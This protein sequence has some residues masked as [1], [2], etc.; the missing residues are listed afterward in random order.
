MD[1]DRDRYRDGPPDRRPRDYNEIYS[2]R[3]RD[4][5]DRDRH[6]GSHRDYDRD[7]DRDRDRDRERD[8][9][10]DRDYDRD[11]DHDRYWD[12]DRRSRDW[13]RRRDWRRDYRTRSPSPIGRDAGHRIPSS[14]S[15]HSAT[16]ERPVHSLDNSPES[17]SKRVKVEPAPESVPDAK[18]SANIPGDIESITKLDSHTPKPATDIAQVEAPLSAS[19]SGDAPEVGLLNTPQ[20]SSADVGGSKQVLKP[21]LPNDLTRPETPVVKEPEAQKLAPMANP[22]ESKNNET[23][24]SKDLKELVESNKPTESKEPTAP[25]APM[26]SKEP[27]EPTIPT[28]PTAPMAL[29][30]PTESKEPKEPEGPKVKEFTEGNN[31][32]EFKEP[33]VAREAKGSETPKELK[34][35][36]AKGLKEP[37]ESAK[38]LRELKPLKVKEAKEPQQPKE[39]RQK[40]TE[41]IDVLP[42]VKITKPIK[43]DQDTM[44]LDTEPPKGVFTAKDTEFIGPMTRMET[45]LALLDT[46]PKKLPFLEPKSPSWTKEVSS[47]CSTPVYTV[48]AKHY[49]DLDSKYCKYRKQREQLSSTWSSFCTQLDNEH[50]ERTAEATRI[51]E[52]VLEEAPRRSR[53]YGDAARSE[54]EFLEIL[55]SLEMQTARDP[56][57]RARLTSATIPPRIFDPAERDLKF[58]DT[59]EKVVDKN[60]MLQRLVKDKIDTFSFQEHE[61]FAQAYTLYPKE[62]GRIADFMGNGRTFHECVLHY[63]RTKKQADYK[64]LLVKPKARGKRGRK[65]K[66]DIFEDHF[67]S[68]PN[69]V[70]SNIDSPA[71]TP[72]VDDA[73]GDAMEVDDSSRDLSVDLKIEKDEEPKPAATEPLVLPKVRKPRQRKEKKPVEVDGDT[74][75]AAQTL[76]TVQ[77][78]DSSFDALA[79][80]AAVSAAAPVV[81]NVG[82]LSGT[83]VPEESWHAKDVQLFERLLDLYGTRWS[84]IAKHVGRSAS[85]CTSYFEQFADQRGYRETAAK[86][87]ERNAVRVLPVYVKANGAG[88]NGTSAIKDHQPSP[89]Q[90]PVAILNGPSPGFFA[91]RP[92]LP[93]Q[94]E[95]PVKRA[96]PIVVPPPVAP[97]KHE[98]ESVEK[99]DPVPIAPT[100]VKHTVLHV[101]PAPPA[102]GLPAIISPVV[103]PVSASPPADALGSAEAE[104][105]VIKVQGSVLSSLG[106]SDHPSLPPLVPRTSSYMGMNDFMKP[107]VDQT[108][109]E[110]NERGRP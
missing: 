55:A 65:K 53:S 26:E 6:R 33:K 9:D 93:V 59:N 23:K 106:N 79:T 30:E 63:Y 29:T 58:Q 49:G 31:V 48:I 45:A 75:E 68:S 21:N 25:T 80:L 11:R 83:P 36:K 103:R 39:S 108:Y 10:R 52:N 98:P 110:S 95:P 38:G 85:T 100:P 60:A 8:R 62:F 89:S 64:G 34:E 12:R 91:P 84:E 81:S 61:K 107:Y 92:H 67:A 18:S 76:Q 27:M 24:E 104:R 105:P 54:A 42:K 77:S 41:L 51:E 37:K 16:P 40:D 78:A 87:D 32:K 13:D 2:D 46:I 19:P 5:R 3:R 86:A 66:V 43:I 57:V 15:P 102:T 56:L 74:V 99:P 70:A 28:V 69:T 50:A 44:K 20:G 17:A 109:R 72:S 7:Y 88:H 82:T 22:P 14:R 73:E 94:A 96:A 71:G 101:A 35:T 1:R 97:L 4:Y 47:L 90:V